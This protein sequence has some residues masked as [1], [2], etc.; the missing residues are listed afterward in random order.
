MSV[1]MIIIIKGFL[2][3]K[4]EPL[5]DFTIAMNGIGSIDPTR[6]FDFQSLRRNCAQL[7]ASMY[8]FHSIFK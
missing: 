6:F 7:S 1:M 4:Y 3:K 8:P 5:F 2:F